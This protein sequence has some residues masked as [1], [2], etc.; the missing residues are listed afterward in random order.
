M[1]RLRSIM[2]I[3][4]IFIVSIGFTIFTSFGQEGN[5]A[6]KGVS[7]I[8]FL[9]TLDSLFHEDELT[10]IITICNGSQPDYLIPICNSNLIAVY[11]FLGDSVKSWNLLDR[12]IKPA[13]GY[14]DAYSLAEDILTRDQASF[15][16]FLRASTAKDYILRYIDSFY[17]TE[18]VYDKK[19]G[20]ELL[21]LLVEDQWVRNTSSLY[22]YFKAERKYLLSSLMDSMQA[23]QAQRDHS[24]KVFNFYKNKNKVFA[25]AEVGRIYYWQL[26]LFFHDWDLERRKFYHQLVIDGVESGALKMEDRAN[27]EAGTEY[28][29]LGVD[30]FF[31]QRATIE[32][33]YKIKYSLPET[34]RIRLM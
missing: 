1:I 22:D 24:T 20:L 15:K 31:K 3:S 34:Y 29:L 9:N 26:M 5:S 30:E 32:E 7:K 6:V 4:T 10:P 19:N 25:R 2:Q 21:H 8:D 17:M 12:E 27:F 18:L 28:I 14:P 33:S 11:Y 16:K 13:K 23:I